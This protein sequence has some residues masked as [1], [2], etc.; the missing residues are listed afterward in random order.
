MRHFGRQSTKGGRVCAF[1]QYYESKTSDDI[2]KLISEELNVKGN[3]YDII[4]AYLNYKNKHFKIYE[5][6]YKSK[7]DDYRNEDIDEKEKF[8][9]AKLIQLSIHQLIKKT[10]VDEL[11]WDF[12]AVHLYPSALWEEKSIYPR[13]ETSYVYTKYMNNDLVKKF[14]SQTFNQ[15]SA[16]L[17]IKYFNHKI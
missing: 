2:L 12:D 1:N 15:G 10:K 6:E 8:I 14:N 13:I 17:K 3:I 11:L 16:I 5:T 9:N 4:E 7:F